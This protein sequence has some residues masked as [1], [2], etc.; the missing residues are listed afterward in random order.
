MSQV[1]KKLNSPRLSAFAY[2]M[3]PDAFARV[4]KAIEDMIAQLIKEKVDEIQHEDFFVDEFSANQLQTEEKERTKADLIA[5][6]EGLEMT[7]NT[8]S[9][10]RWRQL[11][12]VII[13][14]EYEL[15]EKHLQMKRAGVNATLHK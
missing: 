9:Q 6:M 3:C 7:I 8:L 1:A 14:L 2:R 12:E 11:Q 4:K 15:P 13:K 5:K 10:Q